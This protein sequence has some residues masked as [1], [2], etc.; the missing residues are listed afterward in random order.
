MISL[1]DVALKFKSG[2]ELIDELVNFRTGSTYLVAGYKKSG[3]SSFLLG[4]VRNLLNASNKVAY[5]DTELTNFEFG[6][7]LSALCHDIT[8]AESENHEELIQVCRSTYQ[9]LL[10]HHD[11]KDLSKDGILDFEKTLDLA[12]KAIEKGVKI[13][14]FDNLTTFMGQA[15]GKEQGWQILSNCANKIK[16]FSKINNVLCFIVVHTR[17]TVLLNETPTGIRS[18]IENDKPQDIFNK[19]ISFIRKPSGADI[20]G[21]SSYQSQLAGTILVWRPYQQY[22]LRPDLQGLTQIILEDF[23][24]YPGGSARLIFNGA[25]GSFTEDLAERIK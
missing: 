10:I 23:R 18:L 22:D 24:A 13:F 16:D 7:A 21:G 17:D 4:V 1:K 20:Y 15:K 25:K 11:P 6:V 12:K 8:K 5:F 2:Y 19:S 14:V 9:G 3:K